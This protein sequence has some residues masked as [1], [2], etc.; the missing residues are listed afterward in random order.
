MDV[1]QW[2]SD[3]WNGRPMFDRSPRWPALRR[4]HLAREPRCRVCDTAKA[5]EVHH[6]LPVHR[7]PEL[8]LDPD[9]LIT[10]C[11]GAGGCHF[12]WGHLWDW[13]SYNPDVRLDAPAWRGKI[14]ARPPRRADEARG[15][16]DVFELAVLALGPVAAG[17][18]LTLALHVL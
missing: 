16:F 1:R 8:E 5:P 10:L 12:R 11:G 7:A 2:A 13:Y 18:V 14:Q 4:A 3:W 6:V 15:W 9:N 17:L